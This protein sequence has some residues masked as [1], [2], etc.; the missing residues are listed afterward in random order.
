MRI[1]MHI[2]T[3]AITNLIILTIYSNDIK[4]SF[5]KSIIFSVYLNFC[6]IPYI[7]CSANKI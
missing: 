2:Y 3:S 1:N 5:I 7:K 4:A 6:D